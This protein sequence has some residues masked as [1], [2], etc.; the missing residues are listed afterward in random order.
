MI[1]HVWS[2]CCKRAIVDRD[3][4]T[5]S[6]IEQIETI[7]AH[8]LQ[9]MAEAGETAAAPLQFEIV[10]LWVRDPADEPAQSRYRIEILFP[11]GR[12]E[13]VG[14]P[15]DVDLR[16]YVRLRSRAHFEGMPIRGG[17]RYYFSVQ[18][19]E[20]ADNWTEVGRIPIDVTVSEQTSG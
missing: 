19:E 12:S 5:V 20:S 10:T 17:G 4:N 3:T 15:A 16:S 7:S 18:L 14:D 6:L 13:Y 8:V 1:L 9:R 11:D 2:V